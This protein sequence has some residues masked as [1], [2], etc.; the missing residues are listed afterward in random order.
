MKV[1]VTATLK[2]LGLLL[3]ELNIREMWA[4]RRTGQRCGGINRTFVSA[5]PAIAPLPLFLDQIRELIEKVRCI[6]GAGRSFGMILHTEDRQFLVP[7]SLHGAV[8]QIDVR[9]FHI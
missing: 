8:V 9:Y 7:H 2:T 1:A 3:I 4:A 6:M 5:R